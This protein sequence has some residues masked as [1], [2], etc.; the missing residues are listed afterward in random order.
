MRRRHWLGASAALL[1]APVRASRA[2]D[3]TLRVAFRVAETGFDPVAIGDE[4]SNRVAACI[5]EIAADLRPP[6]AAVTMQSLTAEALPEVADDFR[7]FT[8]RIRLASS[9]PTTRRSRAGRASWWRRITSTP[10][11]A[12]TTRA[13]TASCLPVGERRRARLTE[14]RER[15]PGRRRSLFDYDREVEGIRALDRYIALR[16][17]RSRGRA[18]HSF[19]QT[20]LGRRDRTRGGRG[21]WRRYRRAPGGH[22]PAVLAAVRRRSSRIELVRNPRYRERIFEATPM[23]GDAQA[24]AIARALAGGAAAGR[25]R[26]DQR[27]RGIAAA[28]AGLSRRLAD[29][30]ELPVDFAPRCLAGA[31]AA[32]RQA[33]RA[34]AARAA[35][36]HGDDLLQHAAPGWWAAMR[37]RRWRC[38]APSRWPTT[39]TRNCVRCATAGHRGAI[40]HPAL[41]PATRAATAATMSAHD[42]ARAMALLDLYGIP[43]PQRRWLARTARRLAA[44]AAPRPP[45]ARRRGAATSCGKHYGAHGPGASSSTSPP[46]RICSSAA[47]TPR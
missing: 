34:A 18:S 5:F 33:R 6:G 14:L 27:D 9:S 22:G 41:H 20:G 8:F 24:Q 31:C 45:A 38:A 23:P 16:A 39:T 30:I 43:R 46:G 7:S 35:A 4:N 3:N 36:R 32:S 26:R 11:S 19:A 17:P 28:L 37:R 47:A 10:S 25:T 42:P 1:A 2:R 44:A 21:L 40:D 15:A 13:T 12:T 29:Q